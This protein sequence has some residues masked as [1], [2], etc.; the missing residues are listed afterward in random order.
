MIA[1]VIR[2]RLILAP[3]L[4]SSVVKPFAGYD[5]VF[6]L[7]GL[8]DRYLPEKRAHYLKMLPADAG[9][10]FVTAFSKKYFPI[11]VYGYSLSSSEYLRQLTGSIQ[12]HFHSLEDTHYEPSRYGNKLPPGQLLAEAVCANPHPNR[13]SRLV[14]L[15]EVRD[16]FKESGDA[17]LKPIPEEGWALGQVEAALEGSPYPGLLAYCR[18]LF[19][20]TGNAW[21]DTPRHEATPWNAKLVRRLARDWPLCLALTKEVKSFDSWLGHQAANRWQEVISYL[22]ARIPKTLNEVLNNGGTN[23]LVQV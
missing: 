15:A 19:A 2:H 11:E 1:L 6:A 4:L 16:W 8:V 14:V 23:A 13:Y 12:A 7:F 17:L 10:A 22:A 18:W 9:A 3:V 5:Q 20:A 21:L